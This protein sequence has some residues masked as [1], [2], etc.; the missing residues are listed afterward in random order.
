MEIMDQMDDGCNTSLS[1][2]DALGPNLDP[3]GLK[4]TIAYLDME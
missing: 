2:D 3:N 4:V 1:T